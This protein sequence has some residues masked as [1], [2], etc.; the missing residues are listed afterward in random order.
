MVSATEAVFMMI[1][2]EVELG[3]SIGFGENLRVEV[4][5]Q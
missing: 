2:T 5:Q 3:M 4:D 1:F